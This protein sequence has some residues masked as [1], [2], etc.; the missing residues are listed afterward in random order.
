M[1]GLHMGHCPVRANREAQP[2]GQL[3]LPEGTYTV[4]KLLKSAGYATACCGKWGM[5]MF[6]TTGSP[7]KMGF[8]HFFGFLGGFADHFSGGEGY[9]LDR[10]PFTGFGP[11]YYSADA[12]TDR[13]IKFV[14]TNLGRLPV[15]VMQQASALLSSSRAGG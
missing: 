6:D 14:E 12:F 2:E 3:P 9:R 13:A 5:G 4:A 1:T 11:D 8:D 10:K 7:L 15:G